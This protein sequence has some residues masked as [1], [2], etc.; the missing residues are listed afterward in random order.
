[1]TYQVF[2]IIVLYFS[3]HFLNKISKSKVRVAGSFAFVG[4]FI[5]FSATVTFLVTTPFKHPT[6]SQ[7][8]E[9][10]L[11]LKLYMSHL[12]KFYG[13]LILYLFDIQFHVN[14]LCLATPFTVHYTAKSI[15][16]RNRYEVK[17]TYKTEK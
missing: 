11:N 16:D 15:K 2:V 1:M 8:K 9:I 14:G 13:N 5:S 10:L 7:N 4:H 3:C 6:I 17:I 12:F